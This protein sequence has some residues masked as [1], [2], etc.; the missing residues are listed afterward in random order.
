MPLWPY[1]WNVRFVP[2]SLASLWIELILRL[3]ELLGPRLAVELV[4]QRLGIERLQ[5]ARA[6][7]P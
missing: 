4:Q 2:S 7:P 1:F 6:R 5:V 3:A